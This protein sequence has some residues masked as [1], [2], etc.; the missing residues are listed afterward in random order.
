MNDTRLLVDMG[1]MV[2]QNSIGTLNFFSFSG[3]LVTS[4]KAELATREFMRHGLRVVVHSPF[5]IADPVW[6]P[7]PQFDEA[8]FKRRFPGAPNGL[9]LNLVSFPTVTPENVIE[10][11]VLW[12]RDG[13]IEHSCL[14]KDTLAVR[15]V[16]KGHDAVGDHLAGECVKELL[17]WL[18]VQSRQWWIGKSY[19]GISGNCQADRYRD[20]RSARRGPYYTRYLGRKYLKSCSR[21]PP[22]SGRHFAT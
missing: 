9:P 8:S 3:G 1:M 6:R 7:I 10:T 21:R 13:A 5:R 15:V 17:D 2:Q 22:S 11:R 18:R 4:N 12:G 14:P 19:E 16:G 20:I